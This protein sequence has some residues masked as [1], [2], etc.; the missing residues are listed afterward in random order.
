[1]EVGGSRQTLLCREAVQINKYGKVVAGF[2]FDNVRTV[3]ALEHILCTV[4][5]EFVK[6]FHRNGD[7]DFGFGGIRGGD[8]IGDAVKVGNDLVDCSGCCSEEWG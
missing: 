5:D 6:A 2:R 3:F 7:E 1:M 4:L 8:V